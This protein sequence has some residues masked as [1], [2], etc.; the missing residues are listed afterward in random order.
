[1]VTLR[2]ITLTVA[3]FLVGCG[4]DAEEPA[5]KAKTAPEIVLAL[6]FTPNPVHAPVYT[7][8]RN[9]RD[10]ERGVRLRI[11]PPGSGPDGV[12]L[13][14]S[15]RADVALLDI[16]DLAIARERNA[17]IVGIGALVGKPLAALVARGVDRPRDLEGRKVGVSGLPS[18]PAFVKAIVGAD[19][20]DAGK[21]RHVTIGFES[22]VAL[23][24]KRVDA[25]PVFWNAEGVAL[26]ERGVD[27]KEFRVED[28]GAPPYPEVLFVTSTRTLQRK[29][30]QLRRAL[31]A[32]RDGVGDVR[33]DPKAAT[34]QIAEEAQAS[35]TK[36]VGAQLAAVAP[37]FSTDLRLDRDVLERWADFDAR[38][39]I[40]DK[41]PEVERAFAFDLLGA[42]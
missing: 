2:L 38:I 24:A 27:T 36:L 15:G 25:A 1:M 32:V 28:Y 11:R 29:R 26:R 23:V 12:R 8:V 17:S 3:A 30:D 33:D 7:A 34:A 35:G 19:G 22:V 5:S 18:D 10:R 6:D 20:G 31:E 39:G 9:N 42:S 4:E 41:R 37:T 14:A 40:V 16:H 13:V 21:V